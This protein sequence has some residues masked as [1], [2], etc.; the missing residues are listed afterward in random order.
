MAKVPV[1]YD[2]S[3]SRPESYIDPSIVD[4]TDA[5]FCTGRLLDG[6]SDHGYAQEWWEQATLPD[7]RNCFRVYL[8]D[9]DDLVDDNGEPLGYEDLPWDDEH[10]ARIRL[11]D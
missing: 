10:V 2:N 4:A 3:D 7:G 9:D 6:S 11:A 5:A 1:T 8:F